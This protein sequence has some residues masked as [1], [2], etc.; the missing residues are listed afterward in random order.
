[1]LLYVMKWVFDAIYFV[2]QW[3]VS[4]QMFCYRELKICQSQVKDIWALI[5]E[6]DYEFTN[7]GCL[8]VSEPYKRDHKLLIMESYIEISPV[9]LELYPKKKANEISDN[10]LEFYNHDLLVLLRYY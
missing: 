7:E 3:V 1:M 4:M 5:S 2:C 8:L 9:V 6:G 10:L